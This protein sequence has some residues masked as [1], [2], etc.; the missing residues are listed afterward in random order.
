MTQL[1]Y[2]NHHE[3][4]YKLPITM[5]PLEFGKLIKQIDNIYIIH[6]K[7]NDLVIIEQIE[8]ENWVNIYRKGESIFSFIDE[9]RSE[10]TFSW[11]KESWTRS[12]ADHKYYF[13]NNNKL[14]YTR[15]LDF[16]S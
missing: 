6:F 3:Y 4:D 7:N 14:I 13:D 1:K 8:N 11:T 16:F 15:V 12:I 9:K 2:Q 5:N 10:E